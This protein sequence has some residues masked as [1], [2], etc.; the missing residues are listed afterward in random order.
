[1]PAWVKLCFLDMAFTP[2]FE[3]AG[4]KEI[5]VFG[6]PGYQK[7]NGDF[8]ISPSVQLF[9]RQFIVDILFCQSELLSHCPFRK[10]NLWL[11]DSALTAVER[12][13]DIPAVAENTFRIE[14]DLDETRLRSIDVFRGSKEANDK[15]TQPD[16]DKAWAIGVETLLRALFVEFIEMPAVPLYF[17]KNPTF[18]N[19]R[20][21][22]STIALNSSSTQ[23]LIFDAL[24]VETI[25]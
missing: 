8:V 6:V 24:I 10:M 11:Y 5:H 14:A 3:G 9:L 25:D 23:S 22:V 15:V 4:V 18:E 21:P 12:T 17:V 13:H 19:E 1:M 16:E 2:Q 20:R 7:T